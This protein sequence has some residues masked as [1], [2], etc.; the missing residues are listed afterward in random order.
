MAGASRLSSLLLKGNYWVVCLMWEVGWFA[1]FNKNLWILICTM[2]SVTLALQNLHE[3]ELCF[4]M[5]VQWFWATAPLS[6]FPMTCSMH[7][8]VTRLHSQCCPCA[9]QPKGHHRKHRQHKCCH[10][11]VPEV[12]GWSAAGSLQ[13]WLVKDP[14]LCPPQGFWLHGRESPR[15]RSGRKGHVLPHFQSVPT[16]KASVHPPW[17]DLI[18]R[19]CFEECG[20]SW[21]TSE[22][23]WITLKSL[24]RAY[25]RL[26][27]KHNCFAKVHM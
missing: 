14:H 19:T 3:G 25:H 26:M 13:P 6:R 1:A 9:H 11:A 27:W 20:L 24:E 4:V 22:S 16:N 2:R 5:M 21:V 12:Q 23:Q 15:A 8:G 10:W 18:S 7:T 17:R